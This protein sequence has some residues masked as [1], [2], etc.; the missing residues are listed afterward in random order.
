MRVFGIRGKFS[1]A[2]GGYGESMNFYE[3][4]MTRYLYE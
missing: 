1:I 2:G 3:M 4:E